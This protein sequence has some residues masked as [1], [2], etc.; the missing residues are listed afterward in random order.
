MA[1]RDGLGLI[2][3]HWCV[4]R[5]HLEPRGRVGMKQTVYNVSIINVINFK[6]AGILI[7]KLN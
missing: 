5:D 1:E 4:H 6:H 2:F 7:I 3:S